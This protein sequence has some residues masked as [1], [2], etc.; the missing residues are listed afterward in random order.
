MKN[1]QKFK[2]KIAEVAAKIA[3]TNEAYDGNKMELPSGV[4]T[5]LNSSI[6]TYSDL[7][8]AIEDIIREII[9]AEPSMK[10]LENKSGWNVIFQKLG[11]L[12]GE[13]KAED[14]KVPAV[15]ASTEKEL[16]MPQ[17]QEAFNRINRK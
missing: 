14:E 13:K 4:L 6:S 1:E 16:G 2:Q 17:L 10:D 15:D 11:Q 8:M 7:A 5:R 12:S 3:G 9:K